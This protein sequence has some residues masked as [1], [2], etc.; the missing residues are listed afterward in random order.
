LVVAVPGDINFIEVAIL[1]ILL[2]LRPERIVDKEII[3]ESGRGKRGFYGIILFLMVKN[4]SR[5]IS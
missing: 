2:N 1:L 4:L 5:K 3:H